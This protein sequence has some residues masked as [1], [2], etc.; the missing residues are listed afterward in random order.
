MRGLQVEQVA[1]RHFGTH[2]GQRFGA[3]VV[4]THHGP[5][6]VAFI[7]QHLRHGAANAADVAC[8]SRHENGLGMWLGMWQGMGSHGVSDSG[9]EWNVVR[10]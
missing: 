2:R 8:R 4:P 7:E 9:L 6:P 1:D 10:R 5:H 3:F